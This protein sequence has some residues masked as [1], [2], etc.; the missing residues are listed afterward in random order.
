MSL[1]IELIDQNLWWRNPEGIE[2]DK[3]I[4]E[5]RKSTVKWNPTLRRKFTLEK[6]IVYTLRGPRQVGK[7]TLLKNM[8]RDLLMQGVN[9]RRMF[10]YTC[11]LV[12]NPKNLVDIVS[13][14]V[15][16]VRP[17]SKNRMYI[18]LDE[19]S[20]V[21]DWQKGIKHLWDTGKLQNTTVILTGSHTLDIKKGYERLPGRRGITND[22]PDKILVPMKFSEYVGTLNPE[23]H[24]VLRNNGLFAVDIRNKCIEDL[25]GGKISKHIEGLLLYTKELQDLFDDYVITGGIPKVINEYRERGNIPESVYKTYIDSIIGDLHRW[26]KRES[27]MRQLTS[28]V[29]ETL[30]NPVSW[31]TLKDGTDVSTHSTAAEYIDTLKDIFVL[32]SLYRLDV[33]KSGPAHEKEKRLHFHDPFI[34]HALRSWVKSGDPYEQTREYVKDPQRVGIIAEG[35][36][37]DHLVRYAFSQSRQKSL[38]SYENVLFYWKSKRDREVDFV[39]RMN[40]DYTPIEVKYQSKVVKKDKFGLIDFSK[41]GRAKGGILLSKGSTSPGDF[42]TIP[43]SIFLALI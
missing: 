1:P 12:D 41:T 13:K 29:L 10:Y 36:V 25:V 19:I 20:S 14:Y 32:I 4:A 8:I 39:L 17:N 11:D 7:T 15:D 35:V 21:R 38:F 6:D 18:F 24:K 43:V 23:L 26:D 34:L 33:T 42:V 5:F 27:Y 40:G 16:T 28:R 31:N 3:H 30:G 22:V 9:P 2:T 37:A